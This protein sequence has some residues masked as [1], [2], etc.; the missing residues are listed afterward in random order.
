M[1]HLSPMLYYG[2]R[3]SLFGSQRSTAVPLFLLHILTCQPPYVQLKDGVVLMEEGSSTSGKLVTRLSDLPEGKTFVTPLGNRLVR[4][5]AVLV[6]FGDGREIAIAE[7]EKFESPKEEVSA[8]LKPRR[9]AASSS[10]SNLVPS[11]LSNVREGLASPRTSSDPE[12]V[13]QV[14]S[15]KRLGGLDLSTGASIIQSLKSAIGVGSDRP[16]VPTVRSPQLLPG[17]KELFVC[18]DVEYVV[19]EH[20]VHP[21]TIF[22]TNY[23]LLFRSSDVRQ[24][25]RE[26]SL[27][28]LGK[29]TRIEKVGGK[30]SSILHSSLTRQL[31]IHCKDFH[32]SIIIRMASANAGQRKEL[33]EL[34]NKRAFPGSV[35]Q[36]FAFSYN[37]AWSFPAK[38]G[39]VMLSTV[40]RSDINI[41]INGWSLF[42]FE[43]E[44]RRFGVFERT[45]RGEPA[46]RWTDVNT[47]YALC[48]SYPERFVVP[49][50]ITDQQLQK[51]AMFRT[52]SRI[53]MLSWLHKNGASIT[54]CSQPKSGLV[55]SRCAEDELIL[56]L[57]RETV[58]SDQYPLVI[59]DPRPRT[60]AEANRAVGAGYEKEA[61]YDKIK[62]HFMG[63]ANIHVVRESQQALAQLCAQASGKT[64]SFWLSGV[65]N[66]GWLKHIK[67]I[68]SAATLITKCVSVHGA[69]CLVHCSDG[70]DR[71][72]QVVSLAMLCMDPFYRTIS[73]FCILIE[74][75]WCRAG[76][77]FA[78]RHGHASKNY[79]EDSRAPIFLQW[80]DCVWQ[81]FRQFVTSFEFNE[82]FLIRV[83][84]EVCNGRFGTF[85]AD[86]EQAQFEM[87]LARKTVSLWT[88][89]HHKDN[90]YR[91]I[92]PLYSP[93]L[94]SSQLA[95]KAP[96]VLVPKCS[97]FALSFWSNSYLQGSNFRDRM[98]EMSMERAFEM[99]CRIEDLELRIAELELENAALRGVPLIS[100]SSSSSTTTSVRNSI[101]LGSGP[102]TLSER[103]VGITASLQTM[104]GASAT[105]YASA[106]S[107]YPSP[108]S[109][110]SASKA[111][112]TADQSSFSEEMPYSPNK[113]SA[114][115]NPNGI[116]GNRRSSGDAALDLLIQNLAQVGA[117]RPNPSFYASS[118]SSM[119]LH[120]SSSTPE[121][122]T[123]PTT[124]GVHDHDGTEA[125]AHASHS[126]LLDN[127]D[128]ELDM[129]EA[130]AMDT[131]RVRGHPLWGSANMMIEDYAPGEQH[132]PPKTGHT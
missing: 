106:S 26:V 94:S 17:E 12:P 130:L 49:N 77:M 36:L 51:V 30:K 93:P 112:T 50:V 89:I 61:N 124:V 69:S 24:S 45:V 33:V 86:N 85:L 13:K 66:T 37:P 16:S 87:D 126:V 34:M 63:I 39:S 41:G 3:G 10:A 19:S 67:T 4:T 32:K 125:G 95:S 46:W 90:F 1:K 70:W 29:I 20:V 127:V 81:V 107:S 54:R 65:E 43:A 108:R 68:L 116:V 132:R 110:S 60:N 5:S 31:V 64:D 97:M 7:D 84:E 59:I 15:E 11:P 52:Q 129:T 6:K 117:N 56:G 80:I 8:E 82:N 27:A 42:S 104:T 111:A 113:E 2:D 25:I 9:R 18:Q 79:G 38:T 62:V 40:M 47:G 118:S 98:V 120:A 91:F 99:T 22:L 78:T 121:P 101:N 76:H 83:V 74:K 14:T 123:M 48:K 92:N 103:G 109:P 23:Q 131:P 119:E 72:S 128:D 35:S 21:G 75:E 44:F 122:A 105:S 96:V 58:E 55:T 73:G 28:P 115:S 88:Y 53:P 114:S 71:T 57:I 102:N 100:S